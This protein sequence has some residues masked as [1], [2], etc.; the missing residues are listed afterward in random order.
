MFQFIIKNKI[1]IKQLIKREVQAN[2]KNTFLGIFWLVMRPLFLL[3]VYS[4][5]F[6]AVLK[7]RWPNS[8]DNG[9]EFAII[10]FSGLIIFNLFSEILNSAPSLIIRNVNYV[11][12][13]IF[14][15][16]ILPIV[17]LGNA[18]F[19]LLISISILLLFYFT[20]FGFLHVTIF[21]IPVVLL[22]FVLLL[23]GLSL[24]MAALG[25]YVRDISQTITFIIPGLMFLSPIFYPISS[26]SEQ[27]RFFIYLNPLTFVVEQMRELII[28][29]HFPDWGG[30]ILYSVIAF[31]VYWGGYQFFMRT[32]KGFADVL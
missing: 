2:Y 32:R 16:E 21:F 28:W 24:L 1:L 19:Q 6:G 4:F 11:K 20:Y 22:P 9:F 26:V 23:C 12:K 25:V 17:S 27:I 8:S 30:L 15:V 3:S 13:V 7:S 5:V 31:I 10:L 14:P 29:G 18:L